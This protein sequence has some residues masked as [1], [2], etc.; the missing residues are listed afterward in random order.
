MAE[1][2]LP[3]RKLLPSE[4]LEK[5]KAAFT[6]S[7]IVSAN[8]K[9]FSQAQEP[10]LSFPEE[11]LRAATPYLGVPMANPISFDANDEELMGII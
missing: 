3:T 6:S 11:G 4:V 5:R 10:Y 7:N 2:Q 8:P 1:E 9:T